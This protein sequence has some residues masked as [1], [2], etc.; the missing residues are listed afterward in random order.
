VVTVRNIMA[1]A[2]GVATTP[3]S[4]RVRRGGSKISVWRFVMVA[5]CACAASSR[6]LFTHR[7]SHNPRTSQAYRV[8]LLARINA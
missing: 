7:I 3:A 4:K 8:A 2:S 6:H 1:A 5:A